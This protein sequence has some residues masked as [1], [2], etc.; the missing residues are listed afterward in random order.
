MK[1][2]LVLIF[3]LFEIHTDVARPSKCFNKVSGFCRKKC[4]MG[5][6][7]EVACQNGKLCCVNERENQKYPESPELSEASVPL[8][9]KADYIVLPTITIFTIQI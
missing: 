1:L 4:G 3:L 7:Y 5:E 2:F 6:I 8:D 9:T